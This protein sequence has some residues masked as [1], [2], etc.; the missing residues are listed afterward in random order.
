MVER[1]VGGGVLLDLE[2]QSVLALP[3]AVGAGVVVP[4]LVAERAADLELQ[5]DV[6]QV[7]VVQRVVEAVSRPGDLVRAGGDEAAVRRVAVFWSQL[8]AGGQSPR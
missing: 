7:V 5:P 3:N 1:V 6:H 4:N 2:P 8:C